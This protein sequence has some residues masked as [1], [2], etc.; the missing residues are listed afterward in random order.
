MMYDY[1]ES[2]FCCGGHYR[3][4]DDDFDIG[5]A[6]LALLDGGKLLELEEAVSALCALK[7]A[8]INEIRL[9]NKPPRKVELVGEAICVLFEKEPNWT[10]FKKLVSTGA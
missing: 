7:R 3:F 9:Y 10:E 5:D 6:D 8:D 2:V 4:E 1:L